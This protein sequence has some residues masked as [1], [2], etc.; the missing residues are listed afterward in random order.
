MA[1]SGMKYVISKSGKMTSLQC[2]T[3]N[4]MRN[5]G[6]HLRNKKIN[7]YK[8]EM[9]NLHEEMKEVANQLKLVGSSQV[10]EAI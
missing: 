10:S 3:A 5:D 8:Q 1:S 9:V 2:K 6:K 4:S 7:V